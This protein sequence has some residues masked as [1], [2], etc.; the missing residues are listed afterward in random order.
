MKT[1]FLSALTV[2]MISSGICAA[3]TVYSIIMTLFGHS[4]S[5]TAAVINGFSAGV[6]FLSFAATYVLGSNLHGPTWFNKTIRE[7][8]KG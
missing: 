4:I 1:L 7:L 3:L 5:I 8:V 6:M 2:L